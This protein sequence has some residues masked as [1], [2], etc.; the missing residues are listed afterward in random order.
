MLAGCSKVE[1][2]EY[3]SAIEDQ[4]H[5]ANYFGMNFGKIKRVVTDDSYDEVFAFYMEKLDDNNPEVISH[6]LEDGRQTAITI[7]KNKY[8]S[9][10]VA[11]QEFK[12]DG[13][14]AITYM[15]LGL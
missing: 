1:V 2:P 3:P 14:V 6:T 8:R 4:V 12:K 7:T 15:N 5:E 11:I 9:V 10:T 13:K